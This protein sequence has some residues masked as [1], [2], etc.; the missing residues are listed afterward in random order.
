MSESIFHFRHFSLQQ[1]KCAM[2][3][4]TDGVLLGSWVKTQN[5]KNILDIGTG[6]GLLA[7]MMAQKSNARIDAIDIDTGAF[8]QAA[9]NVQK[10]KWKKRIT[11]H[12]ISLQ[13]YVKVCEKKYDL[14]VSNPPFFSATY[15]AGTKARNIARHE[16]ESLSFY[17]LIEGVKS[18]L[19]A[20]G[21]FCVILPYKEGTGF[22]E[23][24]KVNG[25]FCSK[26]TRVKTKS[27]RDVKRLLLQFEGRRKP[28]EENTII[29]QNNDNSFTEEY[30]MLTREFYPRF[31]KK[32]AVKKLQPSP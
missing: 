24:A 16:D 1:D 26:L 13:D 28:K 25:L 8:E 5:E 2:K 22:I 27:E 17:E 14:I 23:K 31:V 19:N 7:L 15:R 9:E 30:K 10:S 6:P 4:G 18:L 12:H 3:V 11:V 29:I 21:R 32:V 20:S